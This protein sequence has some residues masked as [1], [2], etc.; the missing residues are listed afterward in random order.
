MWIRT[1]DDELVNLEHIE[2]VL[3]EEDDDVGGFELR[4]YST[5]WE[6]EGDGEFYTLSAVATDVE[7]AGA[8]DRLVHALQRGDT[9]VDFRDPAGAQWATGTGTPP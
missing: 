4:A 8:M 1:Q 6:P 5:G 9:V 2:Y 3:V 7:G